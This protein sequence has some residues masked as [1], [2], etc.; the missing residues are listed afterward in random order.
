[1]LKERWRIIVKGGRATDVRMRKV[2]MEFWVKK[3][4]YYCWE[5]LSEGKMIMQYGTPYKIYLISKKE[6]KRS[7]EGL[8]RSH[9]TKIH[10]ISQVHIFA[11]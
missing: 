11:K 4:G 7:D 8:M 6:R 3:N 10:A 5:I 2:H 9:L 1:M